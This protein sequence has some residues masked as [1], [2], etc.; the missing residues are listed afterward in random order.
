MVPAGFSPP[1]LPSLPSMMLVGVVEASATGFSPVFMTS[2]PPKA[3][4]LGTKS[5][6]S[7]VLAVLAPGGRVVVLFSVG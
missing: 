7:V 4:Q 1:P 3:A 6:F 2:S 5:S